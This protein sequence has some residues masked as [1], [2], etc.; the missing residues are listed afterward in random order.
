MG[1]VILFSLEFDFQKYMHTYAVFLFN[2]INKWWSIVASL[3]TRQKDVNNYLLCYM[4]N[5]EK[6]NKNNMTWPLNFEFCIRTAVFRI[7]IHSDSMFSFEFEIIMSQYLK[8][9]SKFSRQQILFHEI[10]PAQ[11]RKILELTVSFWFT[12]HSLR[13]SRILSYVHIMVDFNSTTSSIR[14]PPIPHI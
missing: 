10:Q 3:V 5:E 1:N 8:I 11:L 7:H 12:C 4:T 14:P 2:F 6:K 9:S 13:V